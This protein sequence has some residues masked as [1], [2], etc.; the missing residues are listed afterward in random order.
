[1]DPIVENNFQMHVYDRHNWEEKLRP[2]KV[3]GEV[4]ANILS[5]KNGCDFHI[6]GI[7]QHVVL[8]NDSAPTSAAV[9]KL[10]WKTSLKLNTVKHA[11]EIITNS[12]MMGSL[13][14][15]LPAV[16]ASVVEEKSLYKHSYGEFFELYGKFEQKHSFKKDAQTLAKMKELTG[17]KPKW[18][19]EYRE[20]GKTKLYPLPYAVRQILAH[21]GQNPNKLDE[22]NEDIRE[23]IK[24]LRRWT[25]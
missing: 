3:G 24:L 10:D 25:R 9:I 5:Q 1:M 14:P 7:A 18:S 21:Q 15:F 23:S 19:K 11:R 13:D 2:I 17:D 4:V 12:Y 6:E 20:R 22:K 8:E 16:L